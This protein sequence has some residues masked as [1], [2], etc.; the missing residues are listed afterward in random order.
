MRSVS[1]RPW[2]RSCVRRRDCGTRTGRC[3]ATDR[4]SAG[5]NRDR[6]RYAGERRFGVRRHVVVAFE[7]V[8]VI[9]LAFADQAVEHGGHVGTHVRIGVFV[10]RQG[11]GSVLQEQVEQPRAGQRRQLRENFVGYQMAAARTGAQRKL[12]LRYH[13]ARKVYDRIF[14]RAEECRFCRLS[15]CA[16]GKFLSERY[17]NV[18]PDGNLSA[19]LTL[20]S[21]NA[22]GLRGFRSRLRRN[23]CGKCG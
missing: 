3:P 21:G 7:R 5:R 22:A 15:S 9:G 19:K 13:R 10:D 23:P 2:R 8:S 20:Y 17:A 16:G 4:D 1:Q 18:S 6:Q 14:P 11:G 12:G